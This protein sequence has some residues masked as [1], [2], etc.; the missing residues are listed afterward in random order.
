MEEPQTKSGPTGRGNTVLVTTSGI[1]KLGMAVGSDTHVPNFIEI[2]ANTSVEKPGTNLRKSGA[3]AVDTRD[4]TASLAK[5]NA[6]V[7]APNETVGNAVGNGKASTLTVVGKLTDPT[8]ENPNSDE[9]TA[10]TTL[11][12]NVAALELRSVHRV[13]LSALENEKVEAEK[14][15]LVAGIT[16]ETD[17]S[18]PLSPGATGGRLFVPAHTPTDVSVR[19]GA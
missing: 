1:A 6:S 7:G 17:E 18:T 3:E 9:K 14:S 13:N 2:K 15:P 8:V 5:F 4:H 10:C 16:M 11:N 12:T 19:V